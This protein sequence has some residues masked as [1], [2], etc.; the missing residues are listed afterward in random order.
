M[1]GTRTDTARHAGQDEVARNE[2]ILWGRLAADA[3]ERIL[4]SG[5]TI[6]TLRMVVTRRGGPPR[7]RSAAASG[8]RRASVDTIDVVC[9]SAATRR[10]AMRLHAGDTIEVEGA[11]R[12]R[13]F[14][15]A[16]GRQSRY[17]VEAGLLRRLSGRASP[18]S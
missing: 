15:S 16:A 1:A 10:A 13:F 18:A 4:P 6:A 8:S 12:R 11:L 9:W 2:V 3:E 7:P 14:G 17:E 5:D